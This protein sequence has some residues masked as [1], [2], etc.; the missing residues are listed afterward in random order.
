MPRGRKP[1]VAKMTA[2]KKEEGIVL[3]KEQFETL[4]KVSELLRDARLK[5]HTMEDCETLATMAFA[6]GRAF[7]AADQAEDLIDDLI[8]EIDPDKDVDDWDDEDE[9]DNY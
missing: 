6:A 9:D 7:V 8:S 2:P 4:Q 3:T 1:A 5:L